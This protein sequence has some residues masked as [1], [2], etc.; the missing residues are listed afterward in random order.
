MSTSEPEFSPDDYEGLQPKTVAIHPAEYRKLRK[1]SEKATELEAQVAELQRREMFARAGIP[2]DAAKAKYFVEGYRG[3]LTPE[4]IR[5]AAVE[6]E[7]IVPS[8]TDP[9]EIAAHQAAANAAAGAVP[10]QVG[11]DFQARLAELAN[12]HIGVN[13]DQART[14]HIAEIARLA[15]EAGAGIP[16]YPT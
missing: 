14:A 3:E 7:I 2:V 13:D 5:A 8:S 15:K 1:A 9:A 6:A 10:P 16:I 12:R 4:A 11:P